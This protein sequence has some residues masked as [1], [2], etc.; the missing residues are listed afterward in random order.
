MVAVVLLQLSASY[1]INRDLGR[2]LSVLLL[3]SVEMP[4]LFVCLNV[5]FG[6]ATRHGLR[7]PSV[8]VA[9]M[10]L[11]GV[12]GATFG[13]GFWWLALRFPD[14]GLHTSTSQP[15][16]LGRMSL[17]GFT[18]TQSHF[19]LWTLAYV[20][21]L[22]LEDARARKLEAEQLRVTAELSRLRANLEPH[23]LLN[24]LNAIAGLVTEDPREARR[25]LV[26][27]GDLLRDALRGEDEL[28]SVGSQMR[29]LK[30]YAE[31]LEA[32]H[33][34]D[35]SF[36]WDI[37]PETADV[38]LPR[39]LLQPLVENAVKHGALKR[40][41]LGHVS[42]KVAF[43]D[44][45]TLVCEVNDDGPGFD[46][47]PVRE[48]AFGMQSVRRRLELRYGER[49]RLVVDSTQAGTRARVELPRERA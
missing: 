47:Q 17:F 29:W 22:A 28:E 44:A 26:A 18:Q 5:L 37:A 19:G 15:L 30:R 3:F 16:D 25:L 43:G 6:W 32:R 38:P 21:P 41:T 27:L 33:R 1:I 45:Q 39:L 9:G 23:F 36:S 48:G 7:S 34:G 46:D 12:I 24:T 4:V 11:S 42:V 10:G 14:L 35:L 20:L 8:V 13:A 40:S 2:L 31:I 49:G